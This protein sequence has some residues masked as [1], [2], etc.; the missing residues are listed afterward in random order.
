MFI[1][2]V[3]TLIATIDIVDYDNKASELLKTLELCKEKAKSGLK[4]NISNTEQITIG[5][6]TFEVFPNGSRHHAYI[7]HNDLYEIKLASYRSNAGDSYPVFI[8]IKSACL[9]SKGYIKAWEDIELFIQ[10][11]VGEILKNKISRLDICC[12]TDKLNLI[13][14]DIDKFTGKFRSDE[15]YRSDRALSGFTFGSG[16]N[17]KVFCRIYNKTLEIE[18]KR[19]KIWFYDIWSKNNMNIQNVWNIEFQIGRKFFKDYG[20]ETVEES[21]RKL[22]SIWEY[23]TIDWITMRDLTNTRK[24][25]CKINEIWILVQKVFDNIESENLISRDKQLE[26]D[27]EVLIPS[28]MGYLTTYSARSNIKDLGDSLVNVINRGLTYLEKAKESTY[29]LEVQKKLSLLKEC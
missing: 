13:S 18:Q 25:R 8:K 16:K 1:P 2:N 28:I 24:E 17:K 9:W 10:K 3:D 7:L 29:D 5:D 21:L 6:M 12:H 26:R 19:Q 27:S 15:I 14:S 11:N 22:K 20:I 23:C 4:E